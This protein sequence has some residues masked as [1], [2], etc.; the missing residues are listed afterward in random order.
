MSRLQ[1][2]VVLLGEGRV[3]KTS[4]VLRFCKDTFSESQPPTIQ[5]SFLDKPVTVGDKRINLG[6]GE[7]QTP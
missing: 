3:G 1:A 4:L 5:A 7:T 6:R 2:K